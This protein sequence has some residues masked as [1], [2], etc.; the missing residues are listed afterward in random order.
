[1]EIKPVGNRLIIRP[2]KVVEK[3]GSIIL[4]DFSKKRPTSG[5]IIALGDKADKETFKIGQRVVYGDMSPY[6]IEINGEE[7]FLI[8]PDDIWAIENEQ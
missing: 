6:K 2:D 4:P 5:T 1:M 7:L 8:H 3:S